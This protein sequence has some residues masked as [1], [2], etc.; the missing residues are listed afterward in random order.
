MHFWALASPKKSTTGSTNVTMFYFTFTKDVV[1]F[2]YAIM[3]LINVH[4]DKC[5]VMFKWTRANNLLGL[6]GLQGFPIEMQVANN[7]NF[8]IDRINVNL[9]VFFC[10]I[11]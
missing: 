8:S 5:T 1:W 4:P 2:W 6:N 11:C 10:L 7:S 9:G 3:L